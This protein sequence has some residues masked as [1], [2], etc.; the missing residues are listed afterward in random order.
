MGPMKIPREEFAGRRAKTQELLREQGLDGLIA[1]SSYAEREGHVCYLANH[2]LSFPNVLSHS[3]L[4]HAA[5]VL[6]VDDLGALVS[7]GGYEPEKCTG[8]KHARTGMDLVDE[9]TA[10]VKEMKLHKAK[11]G[12]AGLDVIPTEYYKA[13]DGQLPRAQL[14]NANA[15]MENQRAIKSPAELALL[16]KAASIADRGLQV[17]IQAAKPGAWAYEVELAARRAALEAGADFIPRVR[18]SSGDRLTELRWPQVDQRQLKEG[19]LLFLDLIGWYGNYGFDNSRVTV[20]GT[21]TDDQIDY[22]NHAVEATDWMIEALRPGMINEFFYTESR[23]RKILPF[24]HGIGLEICENPW[25]TTTE[26]AVLEPN[27]VLC[28]EPTLESDRYGSIAV[29]DTVVIT[30]TGAEVLN[31]CPRRFW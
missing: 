3:G 28:V 1:F 10:T 11:L 5:L 19:D 15:L 30:E 12:V 16:R 8:I 6:P 14:E 22:L 23:G 9:L 20:V 7:P 13:L 31:E 25:L 4:G 21:P 18:V 24:A 2:H 29:E 17:G 27:M 26:K